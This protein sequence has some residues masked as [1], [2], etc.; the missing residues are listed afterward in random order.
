MGLQKDKQSRDAPIETKSSSNQQPLR[1]LVRAAELSSEPQLATE[2]DVSPL[3]TD[4]YSLLSFASC[5][6]RLASST[7]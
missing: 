3:S 1:R 2:L 6:L 5:S 7:D 4:A